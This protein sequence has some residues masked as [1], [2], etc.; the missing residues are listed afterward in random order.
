MSHKS[1]HQARRRSVALGAREKDKTYYLVRVTESGHSP[2]MKKDLKSRAV[3]ADK[4]AR[5]LKYRLDQSQEAI[6]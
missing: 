4:Q 3:D 2:D 1:R 5:I 6:T